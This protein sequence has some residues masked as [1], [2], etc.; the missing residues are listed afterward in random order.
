MLD[1]NLVEDLKKS[2]ALALDVDE[3]R[4]TRGTNLKDEFNISSRDRFLFMGDI[5]E[6]FD[7]QVYYS[8]IAKCVTFGDVLDLIEAKRKKA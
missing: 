6:I 2:L 5:E 4:F 3:A 1:A 7:V 8:Q